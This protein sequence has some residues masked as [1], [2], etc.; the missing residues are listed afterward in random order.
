MARARVVV[1]GGGFGGL[2]TVRGLKGADVEVT[3]VDRQNFFLFQPLVYQVAT[4]SLSSVEVAVPLRQALRRQR[5]ARVL[6]GEVTGFDLEA[7]TVEVGGLPSGEGTITL[8]YDV[9]AVAGGTR[10]SYFG[11]DEWAP[12]APELKTLDGALDLRDRILSAFEAAEV[13]DDA[14]E[15]EAWLTFVV[16]GAGPTGVEMAGQIAELA[17]DVLPRE[18]RRIDTRTARVLLVEAGARVLSAFSESLSA[19]ADRQLRSLGV[20]PVLMTTVVGIDELSVELEHPGGGRE[21]VASRTKVWGAG[22]AASPLARLLAEAA[23]G[24]TDRAGR[25]VVEPDLTVARRRDVFAFGD[26]AV[27]RGLDLHGVAPVAMQQGRHIA[28]MIRD[29]KREPFHYTD[30]G[31]LATIGRSR[32]VGVVKGIP[33]RGFVAWAMWLGIHIVYLVGFQNRVLVLTRW[34]FAYLTR[35]RGARIIHR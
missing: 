21:R 24:E 5:N 23:G 26:M 28:R 17:R 7:Q 6:L 18:Y 19:S 32:A 33:V 15:R 16:V 20:T 10:Y 13:A 30:K 8:G 9:L 1:V 27:V 29:G 35:G 34:A 11:H 12:Y 22:V 3:L 31:E 14:A 4:G 2:L 25:I